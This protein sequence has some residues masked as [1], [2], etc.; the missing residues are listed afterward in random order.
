MVFPWHRDCGDARFIGAVC[1]FLLSISQTVCALDCGSVEGDGGPVNY[2]V[3]RVTDHDGVVRYEAI[4]KDSLKE[5][6]ENLMLA[7]AAAMKVYSLKKK[8]LSREDA[9]LL[10]KEPSRPRLIVIGAGFSKENATAKADKLQKDYGEDRSKGG[11]GLFTG[12]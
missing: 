7:Y 10:L 3:I 11:L 2:A 1:L 9:N 8:D 4:P 6:K 5:R 12:D